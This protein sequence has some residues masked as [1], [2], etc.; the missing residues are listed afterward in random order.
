[1]K[2][3][4][5]ILCGTMIFSFYNSAKTP[6]DLE[7]TAIKVVRAFE[8]KDTTTINQLIFKKQGLVIIYN[9][10]V[11]STYKI[12]NDFSFDE[13]VPSYLSYDFNITTDYNSTTEYKLI[14]IG[15]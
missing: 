15:A 5:I 12:V 13:H 6:D 9:P 14:G 4:L 7:A 10:G 2:K 11:M 3:L 8:K 1:M